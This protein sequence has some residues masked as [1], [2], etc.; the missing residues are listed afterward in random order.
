L[1]FILHFQR[2]FYKKIFFISRYRINDLKILIRVNSEIE[3]VAIQSANT[4]ISRKLIA[5]Y[6]YIGWILQNS[7]YYKEEEDQIL[8]I[9]F[10]KD[11]FIILFLLNIFMKIIREINDWY[12]SFK[13]SVKELKEVKNKLRKN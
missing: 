4:L 2:F 11:I 10:C 6:D 8:Y 7:A 12:L 5:T 1:L 9:E 13:S 3:L